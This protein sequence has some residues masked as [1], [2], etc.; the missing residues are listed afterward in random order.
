VVIGVGNPDRGD[1]GVGRAVVRRLRER[2]P[3]DVTLLELGRRGA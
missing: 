3:D 1:D 2:V